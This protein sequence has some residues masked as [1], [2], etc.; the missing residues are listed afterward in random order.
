MNGNGAAVQAHNLPGEAQPDA[1]AVFFGGKKGNEDFVEHVF[2]DAGAIVTH[3]DDN[4][5]AFIDARSEQDVGVG[6][7]GCGLDRILDYV[8]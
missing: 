7:P 3:L 4:A 5:T 1:A 6:L 8:D 2:G